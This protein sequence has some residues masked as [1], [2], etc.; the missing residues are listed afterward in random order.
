[1]ENE[2]CR[3]CGEKDL[4]LNPG[5]YC[6]VCFDEL[7]AGTEQVPRLPP[8]NPL[9]IDAVYHPG[10]SVTPKLNSKQRKAKYG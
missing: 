10:Y 7:R 2:R 4:E 9:N 8:L 3:L 6:E 5:G 1:M